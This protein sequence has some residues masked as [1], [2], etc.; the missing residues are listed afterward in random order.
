MDDI[1]NLDQD[2]STPRSERQR[3]ERPT[4]S[5]AS[6]RNFTDSNII[7]GTDGDDS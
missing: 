2:S 7:G 6:L 4:L 5:E 3:W 1:E